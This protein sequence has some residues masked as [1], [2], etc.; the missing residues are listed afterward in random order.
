MLISIADAIREGTQQL[1]KAGVT[2]PRRDAGALIANLL[3]QDRTFVITHAD[4]TLTEEHITVL[5]EWLNRR[6]TGEPLQYITGRQEFFGL[7]FEV[8]KDVLIPRPETELLVETALELLP[9]SMPSLVCDV[10]TGSGCIAIALLHELQKT[11]GARAIA[12]DISMPAL[13]VAKRNSQRHG[14]GALI[15]FVAADCL[16][17]LAAGSAI[18]DA[19]VS[20]PP[21]VKDGALASLQREVRDFEPRNA[22]MAGDDGLAVIRRLLLDAGSLLKAGGHLLFEIGFDQ[23]EAVTDL[24]DR[25]SWTLLNIH[26]DLQGIPR[27]VALQKLP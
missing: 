10:G 11:S 5:R 4:D 8:T 24:I 27:I 2:E 3:G 25:N 17:S 9:K 13:A 14:V 20:N 18:F 16:S 12:I 1:R 22:L 23:D 15:Q 6:A 19:I 26:P 21:Y 7:E